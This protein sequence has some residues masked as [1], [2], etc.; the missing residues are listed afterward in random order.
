MHV[1]GDFGDVVGGKGIAKTSGGLRVSLCHFCV[2]GD[3]SYCEQPDPL[4]AMG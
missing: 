4:R 2:T 3:V 1:V